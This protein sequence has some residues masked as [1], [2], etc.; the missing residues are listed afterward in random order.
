MFKQSKYADYVSIWKK[1]KENGDCAILTISS[2]I[3][4]LVTKKNTSHHLNMTTKN[5]C[6]IFTIVWCRLGT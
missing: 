5:F 1:F 6:N 4:K 3:R 2:V